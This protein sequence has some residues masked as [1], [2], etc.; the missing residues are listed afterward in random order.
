M[1]PLG[2][3]ETVGGRL[4]CGLS[5]LF[6]SLRCSEKGDQTSGL[7]RHANREGWDWPSGNSVKLSLSSGA[8]D[9]KD[10]PWLPQCL[11]HTIDLGDR[12]GN[13]MWTLH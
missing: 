8:F 6:Q 12:G 11:A 13:Q 10:P 3:L 4:S 7:H 1:P 5:A 2:Q 9:T